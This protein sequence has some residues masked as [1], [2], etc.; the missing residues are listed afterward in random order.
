MAFIEFNEFNEFSK[1]YGLDWNEA[2][3]ENDLEDQL[4]KKLNLSFKDYKLT[5][6]DF[7]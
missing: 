2:L 3:L 4:D 5:P 1:E 6:D 7:Y